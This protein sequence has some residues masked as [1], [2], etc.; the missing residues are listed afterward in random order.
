MAPILL[1]VAEVESDLKAQAVVVDDEIVA[2]VKIAAEQDDVSV[3][4][5]AL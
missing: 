2:Q 3:C 5:C 1:G 4:R